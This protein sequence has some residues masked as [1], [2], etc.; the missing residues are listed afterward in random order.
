MKIE[1]KPL[2][3][4]PDG[5]STGGEKAIIL[6]TQRLSTEDGPGIRTTVFFK[7]CPLNCAWCHNPES[8][9]FKPQV[10]WMETRCIGC[11][12]CIK[13]CP[14]GSLKKTENGLERD[15]SL[16]EACG[17]CAAECPAGAQEVLGKEIGLAE[18][19][20]ELLKD[21]VYYD[22]SGGG[23]TLS[24]GEPLAQPEFSA[25]LLQRL[26]EEGVSTALDTCGMCSPSALERTLPYLD[27]IL[28]DL[29]EI[30]PNLHREFTGRGN[31]RILDNLLLVRD[32]IKA[33]EDRPEL[34]I[35]TPLIPGATANRE[36]IERIGSFIHENMEVVMQ[37]WELCAFNNLCRDKYRRLGLEWQYATT[38]LLRKEELLD[39]E[40]IARQSGPNPEIIFATGATRVEN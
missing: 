1:E 28:F 24:G 17:R 35:R 3:A 39:L 2:P 13:T 4:P 18:L 19:L 25:R 26:K 8:I 15:R 30:D 20:E 27:L 29:K 12:I 10:H 14:K 9:S 31:R 11:G 36:T 5:E 16:C 34:W 38:Q 21:K 22:K 37:R 23:V 7:G 32:Y 6:H 33:H 40:Q